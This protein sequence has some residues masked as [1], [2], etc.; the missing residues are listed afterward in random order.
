MRYTILAAATLAALI[1]GCV[2]VTELVGDIEKAEPDKS[3]VGEWIDPGGTDVKFTIDVPEVKGNPKGLMR[4]A[5][6]DVAGGREPCWFFVTK[7]GKHNY[8]NIV[9]ASDPPKPWFV[10]FAEEGE[11]TTWQKSP[12]RFFVFRYNLDGDKLQID[13]GLESEVK[14]VMKEA[15]IESDKGG[16]SFYMTPAGWLAKYLEKTGPDA[17]YDGSNV[18]KY[19]KLKKK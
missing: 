3:L 6:S 12:K 14:M 16:I 11:F 13:G 9:V 19:Q 8:A 1:A 5:G 2:P 18:G 10:Q 7:I 15:K 4:A 17:I